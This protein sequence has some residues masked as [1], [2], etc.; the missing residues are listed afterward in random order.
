MSTPAMTTPAADI[1]AKPVAGALQKTRRAIVAYA[2]GDYRLETVPVPRAGTDDIIVKV[3]A[4]GIC[5]GDIKS[6]VGAASVWG[7][8]GQHTYIKAPMIPGHE[9]IGHV[10]ELGENVDP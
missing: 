6:Y 8:N 1:G 7:G 9:F 4:C 2:P 3:E 10:V 5:A